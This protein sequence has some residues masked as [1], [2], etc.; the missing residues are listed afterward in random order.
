[1]GKIFVISAIH[2]HISI[3][4]LRVHRDYVTFISS[5]TFPSPPP[6]DES[7][8]ESPSW[9]RPVLRRTRWFNLF[10]RGDRN[11]AACAVWTLA[12]R[13]T[14]RKSPTQPHP[15]SSPSSG[16][17]AAATGAAAT[18]EGVETGGK[19]ADEG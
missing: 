6:A 19:K 12:A 18:A 16:V 8:P 10:D 9:C 1:M 15:S 17:A 14:L 11:E 4:C 3:A 7:G 2:T 13:L 5:G